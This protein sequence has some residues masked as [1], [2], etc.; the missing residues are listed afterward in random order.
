MVVDQQKT[1]IHGFSLRNS[2]SGLQTSKTQRRLAMRVLGLWV[3]G[4]L[5]KVSINGIGFRDPKPPTL[6]VKPKPNAP[7]A[8][9]PM[10]LRRVCL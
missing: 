3:S 10:T 8:L 9:N 6:T 1:C 4:F 5:F 2:A 7:D